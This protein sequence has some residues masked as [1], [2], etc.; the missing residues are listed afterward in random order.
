MPLPPTHELNAWLL[1]WLDDEHPECESAAD[2][3]AAFIQV[4]CDFL[5]EHEASDHEYCT[6]LAVL[7]ELC[8]D[9]YPLLTP[10][11]RREIL[12]SCEARLGVTIQRTH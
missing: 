8:V 1:T 4:A 2:L 7:L 6:F 12:Q 5:D 9:R 10:E 11:M 3:L